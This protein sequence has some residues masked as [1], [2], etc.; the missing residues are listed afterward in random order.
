MALESREWSDQ[1]SWDAFI[2]SQRSGHYNQSWGWGQMARPL[3]GEVFRYAAT[4]GPTIRAA[5]SVVSNAIRRSGHQALYVSRGPVVDTPDPQIL[6]ILTD[7]LDRLAGERRA[8][9]TKIEPY[10]AAG[11]SLWPALLSRNGF[12]PLHPPSQPRSVWVVDL[13]PDL[14]ALQAAMKPKWRYNIRLAAKRGVEIVRMEPDDID[15]Y[16][17]LYQ[18]TAARDG[19]YI[20]P[21]EIYREIF[22]TFWELGQF[23]LL[24]ARFEGRFIAGVALIHVG[25]TMWYA[26]GASGD[27]DRDV[28]APHAL[29]WEAMRLGKERGALRYDMRGV[30]D[31]P[32]RDQEM[33]GVHRFKQGFG[34]RQ[35]TFL[36]QYAK[37]HGRAM[38]GLWK[39]YW[40][41]RYVVQSLQRRRRGLPHRQWA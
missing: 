41:G 39:T 18:T 10:V 1:K 31:V 25:Q 32:G 37:G 16:Y 7:R 40:Q 19:F 23:E 13:G 6:G 28:M 21:K 26:Y 33:S 5:V 30:P 4:D 2:G 36:P 8:L 22:S 34:G 20:H 3:G 12:A 24:M 35:V 15:E 11:D 14:E 17:R 9:V 27:A 38:Y 29:Q